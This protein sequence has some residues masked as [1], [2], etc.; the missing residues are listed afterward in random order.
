MQ[1]NLDSLAA[2]IKANILTLAHQ[3]L[4]ITVNSL[5]QTESVPADLEQRSHILQGINEGLLELLV[6]T[7]KGQK[8]HDQVSQHFLVDCWGKNLA[9]RALLQSIPSSNSRELLLDTVLTTL[10]RNY[11]ILSTARWLPSGHPT[12]LSLGSFIALLVDNSLEKL[13]ETRQWQALSA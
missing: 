10:I 2:N 1:K 11:R 9:T 12:L 8:D 7:L 13:M 3:K 4:P 5:L 6:Q